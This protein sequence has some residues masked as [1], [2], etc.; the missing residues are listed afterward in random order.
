MNNEKIEKDLDLVLD[1]QDVMFKI[2]YYSDLLENTKDSE[3]FAA[4]ESDIIIIKNE[5]N[6][7]AEQLNKVLE[8]FSKDY[9]ERKPLLRLSST[10]DNILVSY[11]DE[12]YLE[13]FVYIS[14]TINGYIKKCDSLLNLINKINSEIIN[15]KGKK[16]SAK[17]AND[18]SI[19]INNEDD[20][21]DDEVDSIISSAYRKIEK[22]NG[23][24][25]E[26][27]KFF[28]EMRDYN[29][30]DLLHIDKVIDINRTLLSVDLK[31][32][33]FKRIISELDNDYSARVGYKFIYTGSDNNICGTVLYPSDDNY[34]EMYNSLN[35]YYKNELKKL[36]TLK[37][38]LEKRRDNIIN[39][40]ETKNYVVF[41]K[42]DTLAV[43]GNF[44]SSLKD[45]SSSLWDKYKDDP[46]IKHKKIYNRFIT[47]NNNTKIGIRFTVSED[48][49]IGVIGDVDEIEYNGINSDLSLND[50]NNSK[51][52]E[53]KKSSDGSDLDKLLYLFDSAKILSKE[54]FDLEVEAFGGFDKVWSSID[55]KLK[56]G[57]ISN[58]MVDEFK[59]NLSVI[60]PSEVVDDNVNGDITS[61]DLEK[62]KAEKSS[63][64]LSSKKTVKGKRKHKK[65]FFEKI[66]E[67]ISK[68]FGG[69]KPSGVLVKRE[70]ADDSL[71]K[72][73]NVKNVILAFLGSLGLIGSSAY[74]G[75]SA[76]RSEKVIEDSLGQSNVI[77]SKAGVIYET[78]EDAVNRENGVVPKENFE[79]G[80]VSFYDVQSGELIIPTEEELNDPV[81]VNKL[82]E[83]YG[84]KLAEL[85][86]ERYG[87]VEETI[88]NAYGWVP[89]SNEEGGKAR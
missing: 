1:I 59:N 58:E 12:G 62:E 40:V 19:D 46:L 79:F 55:E 48:G 69:E 11:S 51:K 57:E 68:T 53:N 67:S 32:N 37:S 7:Y 9:E 74:A 30:S 42:G 63:Q 31:I 54:G 77:N 18:K 14:N 75:Y 73:V 87:T 5:L 89:S 24:L 61:V 6:N 41:K 36:E 16:Y 45:F 50:L 84:D 65:S 17:E 71:L 39:R 49:V 22:D 44:D 72:K 38:R 82:R 35:A 52:R 8:Q 33:E 23:R 15:D 43:I 20:S 86:G 70:M 47:G 27:K 28:Q 64:V 80:T 13:E 25:D 88:N 60:Y 81:Y 56:S 21:I 3:V 10:S 83:K 66:K 85:L 78:A 34:D 29:Y 26:M 76:D 4:H 2:D